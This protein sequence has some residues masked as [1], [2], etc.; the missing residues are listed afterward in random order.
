[1]GREHIAR[2]SQKTG[3]YVAYRQMQYILTE[4]RAEP[5]FRAFFNLKTK[6]TDNDR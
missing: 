1:M 5:S 3:E 4:P 2:I 6:V